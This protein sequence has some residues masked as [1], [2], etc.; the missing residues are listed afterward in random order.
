M[1]IDD[2]FTGAVVAAFMAL[3]VYGLD[4]WVFA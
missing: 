2:V 4:K 1:R 3:L